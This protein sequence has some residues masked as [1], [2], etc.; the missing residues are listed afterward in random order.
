MKKNLLK[1]KLERGDV[2]TGVVVSEP[3]I[4]AVEVLGLLGFDWLFIDCEHSPMGVESIARLVIAA[5]RRE[6]TPIVRVPQNVPEV[7][8]R[9]LDAGVMGII[10]PGVSTPEDARKSVR[11]L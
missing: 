9:Y 6:I 1:E 10:V 2:A 11:A 8:L 3:A 5:E 7:I 4:Q